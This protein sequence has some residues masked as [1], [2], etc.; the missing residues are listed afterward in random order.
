M[1]PFAVGAAV[2]SVAILWLSWCRARPPRS[3][4]KS[5]T[6]EDEELDPFAEAQRQVRRR[7][8]SVQ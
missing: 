4:A 1:R 5:V 2:G 8:G 3:K 7:S 6:D